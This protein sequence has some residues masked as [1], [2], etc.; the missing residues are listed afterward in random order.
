MTQAEA[1]RVGV[2]QFAPTMDARENLK[3]VRRL[4]LEASSSGTELLIFPELA[5]TGWG[6]SAQENAALAHSLD[7]WL[8][9]ELTD[10]ANSVDMTLICGLYEVS[11]NDEGRP[12]NTLLVLVPGQGVV[13]SHRKTHLYDAFDYCE[14]DEAQPGG[15]ALALFEMKGITVGVVNCYEIRF[16]ERAYALAAAGCDLLTVSAAW[17]SGPHKEE[18]WEVN[19]RA[20]ALEN[21]V[22]VAASSSTGDEVIGR[23]LVIDPVGAV[24]AQLDESNAQWTAVDVTRERLAHARRILPVL[25][26]RRDRYYTKARP[27]VTTDYDRLVRGFVECIW[28]TDGADLSRFLTDDYFS[29]E[30]PDVPSGPE[31]E[32]QVTAGWKEAFPDFVYQVDHVV[33]EGDRV[34][35]FGIISGT[36]LGDYEGI[37]GTGSR[38]EVKTCD[39]LTLREGRICEHR[40]VYEDARMREQL[41]LVPVGGA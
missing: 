21:Q 6:S 5:A 18:H 4:A 22:W 16:P 27:E 41:G 1:L 8:V 38:F 36:H 32:L 7:G 33:G 2:A 12:Y 34:G 24:R 14:S 40:G 3:E 39:F 13:A 9:T 37:P 25:E 15:G 17:P 23:S 31:G 29:H 20:R 30:S 19:L 28:Q 10:I 11:D 26:Q 35:V